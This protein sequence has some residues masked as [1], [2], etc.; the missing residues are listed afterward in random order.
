MESSGKQ[1]SR[2]KIIR[3]PSKSS[4]AIS[5][6]NA[7]SNGSTSINKITPT[8]RIVQIFAP[9]IVNTDPDNFRALVQKLTGKHSVSSSKKHPK[10]KINRA[11]CPRSP[12]S[13]DSK[14][15]PVSHSDFSHIP[16]VG[17]ENLDLKQAEASELLWYDDQFCAA[18]SETKRE[19]VEEGEMMVGDYFSELYGEQDILASLVES[20]F[21]LPEIPIIFPPVI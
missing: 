16:T 8:I 6:L 21:M 11:V 13:A 7:A 4:H 9:T 2:A 18:P 12:S 15:I 5:K 14:N 10:K 19:S 3:G 20:A 1:L 17:Q